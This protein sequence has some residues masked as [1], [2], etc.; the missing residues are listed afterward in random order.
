[1]A[2][3]N[4]FKIRLYL[5]KKKSYSSFPAVTL[6]LSHNTFFVAQHFFLSRNTF[7]VADSKCRQPPP[8]LP[9]Q[10]DSLVLC[11]AVAH[12]AMRLLSF[13]SFHPFSLAGGILFF[14]KVSLLIIVDKN[15][16]SKNVFI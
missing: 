11:V 12:M 10:L 6:F 4:L 8:L 16:D 3:L 5:L 1:M 15:K 2:Y 13:L 9:T 14:M 7:F